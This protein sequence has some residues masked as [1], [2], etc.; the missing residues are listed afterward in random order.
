MAGVAGD[1]RAPYPMGDLVVFPFNSFQMLASQTTYVVGQFLVPFAFRAVRADFTAT[2]VAGTGQTINVQD[3]TG[4]PQVVID[5]D[6]IDAA[7]TAGA[8]GRQLL[9]VDHSKL[10]LA[11]AVLT[12]QYTS[13]AGDTALDA[14]V[15]LWVKP[16]TK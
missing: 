5:D 10:I 4:T 3:D 7:I 6:V 13:G 2:E 11:G 15:T 1:I 8:G 12:L 14:H 9:V 16:T